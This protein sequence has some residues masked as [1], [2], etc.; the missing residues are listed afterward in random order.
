MEQK[1][2]PPGAGGQ[3]QQ[4]QRQQP[5]YD[6]SNGGHFGM[7]ARVCCGSHV[8]EGPAGGGKGKGRRG[9]GRVIG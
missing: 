9:W 5:A 8:W 6:T 7:F 2:P 4:G 1:P 3:A